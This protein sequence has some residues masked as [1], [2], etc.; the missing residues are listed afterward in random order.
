MAS[1][2]TAAE[3]NA[4]QSGT[5]ETNGARQ[6]LAVMGFH[7]REVVLNSQRSLVACTRAGGSTSTSADSLTP[8]H[9]LLIGARHNQ[10]DVLTQ[11]WVSRAW[12]CVHRSVRCCVR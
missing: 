5:F 10:V 6:S 9:Q 12:A 1:R 11:H 7:A 2:M 8:P 4:R 3:W